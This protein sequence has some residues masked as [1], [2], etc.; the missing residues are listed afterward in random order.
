MLEGPK[1][2]LQI[3][4]SV[5]RKDFKKGQVTEPKKKG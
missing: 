2:G 4:L 3:P 5:G 1:G